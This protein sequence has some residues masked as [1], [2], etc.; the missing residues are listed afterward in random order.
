M[1]CHC[2]VTRAID[3]QPDSV[4]ETM[5][6]FVRSMHEKSGL[7]PKIRSSDVSL[8]GA[9]IKV[10]EMLTRHCRYR[11]SPLCGNSIGQ[12]R[13]FLFKYMPQVEGYLHYRNIDVSTVK[14]LALWWYDVK[15]VKPDT[16]K[17][18]ALHDIEQ[19]I[20]ELKHFREHAF[21]ARS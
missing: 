4:L 10:M 20:A 18:T 8:E 16:G 5:E 12:D 7:L 3:W 15:Y 21:K 19:S 1:F 11:S 13:R 17:H 2:F 9:E 6:P 14:E